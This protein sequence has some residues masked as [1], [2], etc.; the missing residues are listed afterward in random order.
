M[1]W[2]RTWRRKRLT[3][4]KVRRKNRIMKVKKRAAQ[5]K[6]KRTKTKRIQR[7]LRTNERCREKR[8]AR[9]TKIG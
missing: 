5:D 4:N 2:N 8:L 9:S 6:K 1:A 7:T 3:T